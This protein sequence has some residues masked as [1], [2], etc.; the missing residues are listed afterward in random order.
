MKI[1]AGGRGTG[2][3]RKL[4]ELAKEKNATIVSSQYEGLSVKAK[5]LGYNIKILSPGAFFYNTETTNDNIIFD[6]A[7]EI[8]I[9][10]THE[11]SPESNLIGI[12]INTDE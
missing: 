3:T 6:N 1:F 12:A 8:L 9:F 10:M 11:V 7:E 4:L 5:S 2:K